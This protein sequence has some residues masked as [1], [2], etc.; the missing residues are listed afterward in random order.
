MESAGI[1]MPGETVLV[2]AAIFAAHGTLNIY[3]VIGGAADVVEKAGRKRSP[4]CLRA[5][6]RTRPTS[7]K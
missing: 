7:A 6:L 2:T 5:C 1:P 4:E 3:G